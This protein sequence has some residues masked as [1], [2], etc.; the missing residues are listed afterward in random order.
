[1][2]NPRKALIELDR[3]QSQA[4][5]IEFL[6]LAWH[7]IE[8][9]REL[10]LGWHLDAIADHL[11]A[12]TSGDITRLLINEPPGTMKS[13]LVSVLWQCW[14]WGP[15]KAA[16]NRV[17]GTS[18][19]ESLAI[20]DN[21]R[22]RRLITSEWFQERWP[23]ELVSDQNAKTKFENTSTG[24][25]SAMS[26]GSLTGDRGDR[27][28]IDD[29]LSV[30]QAKSDADRLTAQETMLE[31]LPTRLNDPEKSAIVMVM[32]RLHQDDPAGVALAKNLGYT[33]LMLPMEFE[34]ERKCY[35]IVRPRWFDGPGEVGRYDADQQRWYLDGDE[36]P[37]QRREF[38]EAAI[39]EYVFP[40]DQ[41]S[42][43]GELLFPDRF[44]QSVV[45]RDKK[46]L[47]AMAS[48]GQMQQ[49][50]APREGGL[51]K[52]ADFKVI[53]ANAIPQIVR[54]TRGWD[55]AATETPDAAQTCG[56]KIGETEERQF[57]IE[58]V[59]R[60]RLGP[61]KV[62]K[63]ILGTARAD[64]ILC[65][66]SLPQDPGQ[67]GKTQAFDLITMLA[68]FT[69]E[70]T[71]ESG[72]KVTRAEPLAAQV[73]AGNVLIVEGPWVEGFLDEICNFPNG[74][75]KDAADAASRAFS[76]L[77]SLPPTFQSQGTL[78]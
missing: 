63:L 27:V 43:D 72:D 46:S 52:R 58:H 6:K 19:R 22:A 51:F 9:A 14:E 57:V 53:K 71:P 29:P 59:L 42:V 50:P 23:I 33:H 13:L 60:E 45:D 41:R 25:R 12:V 11:H 62:R 56:V 48:A 55:L 16:S 78:Q 18:Y 30:L 44:P 49:R 67:A 75:F 36:V 70:A 21:T 5:L 4:D 66:I 20:R 10:K 31:A 76:S 69:V 34:P 64:G 15:M 38:V 8:P 35:T 74:K 32:Q 1:M 54:R 17:I 3:L 37:V 61:A 28:I 73:E 26:F 24:W 77:T 40:Q 65:R 39:W 47:G 68:G 7:Q 2:R